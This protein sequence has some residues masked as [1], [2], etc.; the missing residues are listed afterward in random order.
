MYKFLKYSGNF[1]ENV[2]ENLNEIVMIYIQ[3]IDLDTE[4]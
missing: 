1:T 4:H 3:Y 2:I